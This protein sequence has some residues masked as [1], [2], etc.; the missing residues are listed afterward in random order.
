MRSW[1]EAMVAGEIPGAIQSKNGIRNREVCSADI[2]SPE[3]TKIKSIHA[4]TGAQ[5]FTSETSF[6]ITK[7][8]CSLRRA[9]LQ[10]SAQQ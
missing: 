7:K 5:Y 3:A 10:W 2:K 9:P 8:Q 4:I 6:G 1:V